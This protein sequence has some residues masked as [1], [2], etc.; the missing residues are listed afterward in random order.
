MRRFCEPLNAAA[1]CAI[2]VL[3]ASAPAALRAQGADPDLPAF[4]AGQMRK[5]DFLRLR[6]Q[7]IGT[8]RG[9]PYNLPYDAR[10]KAIIETQQRVRGS[11]AKVSSTAWT[12]LG[13]D[14]IPN[15]QTQSVAIPVSGRV[16]AVEVHPTN[17]NIVY[18]G[19]AQGGVYRTVDGG[20]HWTPIFD[21]AQSLAIGSLALAP[22]DP[23]ILY[24]GTGEA[25]LSLDSYAGVGLYRIDN[26]DTSPNLVGPINPAYSGVPGSNAFGGRAISRILVHPADPATIFVSTS[27]GAM[28][29]GGESPL[30]N[31]LPPLPP[32]GIWRSTNATAAAGS[33]AFTKLTV[34]TAASA[35]D[36]TGNR[37][38]CDMAFDPASPDSMVCSVFGLSTGT[39]GGI[40]RCTNA[41][42]A[43]PVFTKTLTLGTGSTGERAGF[44]VYRRSGVTVIYAAT[45]ETSSGTGCSDINQ[46]GAIRVSTDGGATWSGKFTGGGGFCGGQCFYNVAIAVVPGTSTSN[47][48]IHVGGNVNSASCQ[49]LHAISVDG[50]S[51]FTNF[52][53]GLHA[54]THAITVA[55]SDHSQVWHGDDGGIF[56]STDGG[57]TWT[58]ENNAGFNATQFESIA[59]HPTDPYFSIGGTQDNGTNMYTPLKTWNRVDYGDGGYSAIDQN[60]PDVTNV[61]MYHT[62][63]NQSNNVI[64]FGRVTSVANATDGF[65][66]FLG[67]NATSANG[68]TCAD[69]VLFYAPLVLGPGSPNT[70]YFGSD[71]LYRS[72]NTGTLNT[73]VS[74]APFAAGVPVSAIAVSPQDDNYRIVGLTNGSLFYTTTGNTTL[75]VLDPTGITGV[76]PDKYV[77]RVAFDPSDKN[78]A[79]IA[80]GGYMGGTGATQSHV[81]KV[82]NLGTTPSIAA[83]NSGLP[84]V[85]VNAF[86]V[87]PASSSNLFA[88]TDIGVF[89]STDGGASWNV[90]GT[91]LP[92]VAVFDMAIQKVTRTLRV[93]TH[94][95]G[96]WENS[97]PPLPIELASLSGAVQAGEAVLIRWSTAS[98]TNSYGFEVQ[99]SAAATGPFVSIPGSFVRG[100][101]TTALP[102]S[103]SYTDAAPGSGT[104]YYR[105]KQLDLDG[106]FRYSDGIAIDVASGVAGGEF[107]TEFSLAQSYPNPF[108]PTTTIRYGIP[109]KA[110]VT[111][112]V[113]TA[114][115]QKVAT[116]VNS[117]MD[118]G[119]HDVT[120]NRGGL[121]SGAYFYAINAGDY[122]AS[123]KLVLVR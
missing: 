91:G 13:P 58:S 3:L 122:R 12:P 7:Y 75:S 109:A 72:T 116:L 4:M 34:T 46:S 18:V 40:Y 41:L 121:A 67:C 59:L 92:V 51:T 110:H 42:A 93:A 48:T 95:R 114:L 43:T 81:W 89:N 21:G 15:G 31:S 106:T 63:F 120:F 52:D 98:E 117:T 66:N 62:Y 55:P 104:V 38:I 111:L 26:A 60:A 112:E 86:V 100:H 30:G 71:R 84:D 14:P 101:G 54:D 35:S 77:A 76:I 8:L 115:G 37:T 20:A 45:A 78:T 69:A 96:M 29:I 74:Q 32:R 107:P 11:L 6:D 47:D 5:D 80:I 1:R 64:G 22:S 27:S 49:R 17:P 61:T 118:A 2:L 56:K 79:Y 68:I 88:G 83:V 102:Q 97:G 73:V 108:N 119:Y 103:Y 85:P 39:D 113:F 16:T 123:K 36:N 82:T 87:D 24:V 57:H 65:W 19:T 10:A 105:L 44:A 99:K 70:V 53:G 9:L 50:G 23:T 25:N 90:F 33:V 28:G 94:G